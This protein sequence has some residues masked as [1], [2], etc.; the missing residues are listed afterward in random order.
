MSRRTKASAALALVAFALA[1][2]MPAAAKPQADAWYVRAGADG[3]ETGSKADP[4]STLAAAESASSAGDRI[5]VL[6]SSSALAA[7]IA[8][9]PR[10]RLIGAGPKVTAA[11]A[12]AMVAAIDGAAGGDGDSVTLADRTV[13][14]NLRITGAGRGAVYGLNVSRVKV[15]GN[16]VSGHNVSCR[17]AF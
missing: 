2:T 10:Q 17:R 9:K 12:G 3:K 14:R 13:V 8:L 7:G 11:G 1:G 6:R 15:V 16:D 4:F 5:V